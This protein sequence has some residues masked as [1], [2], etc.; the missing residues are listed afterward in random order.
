V[1]VDLTKVSDE[2]IFSSTD[3]RVIPGYGSGVRLTFKPAVNGRSAII[4]LVDGDGVELPA[5]LLGKLER[6]GD[7]VVVGRGGEVFASDLTDN[8]VIIIEREDGTCRAPVQLSPETKDIIIDAI[9]PFAC[10]L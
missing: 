6:T 4:A 7:D 1:S 10:T 9:G 8:D 2:L 5:G 3:E